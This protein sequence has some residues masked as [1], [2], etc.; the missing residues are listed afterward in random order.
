MFTFFRVLESDGFIYPMLSESAPT[1]TP[2]LNLSALFIVVP[3]VLGILLFG[4]YFASRTKK[5]PQKQGTLLT[6]EVQGRTATECRGILSAPDDA[7]IFA[8]TLQ[9]SEQASYLH[10]TQHRPTS[11]PLDSLYTLSF[12]QERPAVFSLKFV[13][14]AFGMRE[15]IIN[16]ALMDDFFAQKLNAHPLPKPQDTPSEGPFQGEHSADESSG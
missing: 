14:E 8:Y 2:I 11:Q 4:K 12:E 9:T 15:P 5:R 16:S 1:E 13:R 7:D 6:Y 3:L 10:I